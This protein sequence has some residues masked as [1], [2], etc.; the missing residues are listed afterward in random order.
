[1]KH[2]RAKYSHSTAKNLSILLL[3]FF[4]GLGSQAILNLSVSNFIAELD[5]KISNA[6]T[7]TLIGEEIILEIQKMET[8]FFEMAALPNKHLRRILNQNILK[9]Q[10]EIENALNILNQGGLYR[11]RIDLNLPNTDVE[12]EILPYKPVRLNSFS[13]AYAD[14]VPKFESINQKL[15]TLQEMQ[16]DISAL[17]CSR[18]S[19]I[20]AP[21]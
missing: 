20:R 9:Q 10:V 4:I 8:N 15:K 14:I 16:Q 21:H 5:Q 17:P 3:V 18:S 1:M 6:H 2:T 7:E 12:Y 11:Y 19:F 13:F